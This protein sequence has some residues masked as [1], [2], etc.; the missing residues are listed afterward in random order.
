VF[1]M[2]IDRRTRRGR[3]IAAQ[4]GY[5]ITEV[6]VVLTT[7]GLVTGAA[8]KAQELIENARITGTISQVQQFQAAV[9]QF[10]IKFNA[11]PG[12]FVQATSYIA[13]GS[14]SNGN[15][16]GIISFRDTTSPVP[17]AGVV[18]QSDDPVGCDSGGGD[19]S[20][21]KDYAEARQFWIHLAA[22]GMISGV[23]TQS[24]ALA[25]ATFGQVFPTGK[26]SSGGGWE[27][28]NCYIGSSFVAGSAVTGEQNHWFRLGAMANNLT[29]SAD[30]GGNVNNWGIAT[31]YQAYQFDLRIDDGIPTM[32]GVRTVS[33]GCGIS[34]AVAGSPQDSYS[35]VTTGAQTDVT[36]VM[37]FRM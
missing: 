3:S 20:G 21:V 12:D 1:D 29:P 9:R 10:Q 17:A 2:N 32:G 19:I 33:K 25:A 18:G 5:T 24:D 4:A 34:G 16:N 31:G 14:V 35:V 15:G 7:M 23:R 11:L 30:P 13:G 26:L 36:C 8:L 27:I 6:A 28:V 37:Y 22:S